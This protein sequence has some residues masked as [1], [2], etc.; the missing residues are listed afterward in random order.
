MQWFIGQAEVSILRGLVFVQFFKN[1]C[2][3]LINVMPT[4][5]LGAAGS[6]GEDDGIDQLMVGISPFSLHFSNFIAL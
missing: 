3:R 6:H 5:K 1:C 2:C 4:K